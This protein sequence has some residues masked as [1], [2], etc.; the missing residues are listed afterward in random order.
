MAACAIKFPAMVVVV[1]R[2][3]ALPIAQYTFPG[4]PGGEHGDDTAGCRQR[5]R[6]LEDPDGIRVAER[7]EREIPGYSQRGL[8]NGRINA[9]I[10]GFASYVWL[11]AGPLGQGR[12]GDI[13]RGQL[14]LG[15]HGS[16]IV[17][18]FRARICS[19][20]KSSDRT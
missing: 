3:A 1:P 5:G 9:R 7:V 4:W 19:R 20:W 2:V 10:E 6:Y 13:C 11:E 14:S 15:I 16:R 18:V 17:D 12:G 8:G